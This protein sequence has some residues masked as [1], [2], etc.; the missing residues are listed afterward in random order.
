MVL[1]QSLPKVCSRRHQRFDAP[2]VVGDRRDRQ[3]PARAVEAAQIAMSG[4]GTDDVRGHKEPRSF[5]K[6][7][8]ERIAQ[9]DRRPFRI[10]AAR[11]RK[12]VKP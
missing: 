1:I 3:C 8:I 9:I 2:E 5:D 12:L 4:A 10:D 6:A 7:G 11:S